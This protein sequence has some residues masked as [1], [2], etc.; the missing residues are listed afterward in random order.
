M[1]QKE[2]VIG[3][4]DGRTFETDSRDAPV[5]LY[6]VETPFRGKLGYGRAKVKLSRLIHGKEV[7]VEPVEEDTYG[8]VLA[9]VAL[10]GQSVNSAM[11]SLD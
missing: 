11:Q 6:E 10:G 1:P 5:R 8:R 3:I 4:V 7:T 2:T 9:R